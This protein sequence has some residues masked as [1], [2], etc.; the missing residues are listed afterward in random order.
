MIDFGKDNIATIP[1]PASAIALMS[2]GAVGL[3]LR[4]RR[5]NQDKETVTT[6]Q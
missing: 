3:V 1:E 5:Q 4:R 2:V 6:D